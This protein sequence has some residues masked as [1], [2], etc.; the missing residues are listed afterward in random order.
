MPRPNHLVD[1]LLRTASFLA[2]GAPR[3]NLGKARRRR[4]ISTAYYAVFQALCYV[5]ADQVV[6]WTTG[7]D[8]IEPVFRS[9]DHKGALKALRT[10]DDR[11]SRVIGVLVARLQE[12]RNDADYRPPG[13]NP[14]RAETADLIQQAREADERI[15]ALTPL[16]RRRLVASILTKAR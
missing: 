7:G 11:D 10:A 1:D 2:D 5:L 6:S 12:K 15:H 14:G 16:Q 3:T 9:L 8:L 4:A 13:Y